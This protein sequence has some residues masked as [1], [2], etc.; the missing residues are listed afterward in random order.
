MTPLELTLSKIHE[1]IQRASRGLRHF[2]FGGIHNG[3]RNTK[4]LKSFYEKF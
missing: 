3:K 1:N 4:M 2:C